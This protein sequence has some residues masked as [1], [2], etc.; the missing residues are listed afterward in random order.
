MG[1]PNQRPRPGLPARPDLGRTSMILAPEQENAGTRITCTHAREA[2]I[3]S[4]FVR[5]GPPSGPQI[6]SGFGPPHVHF[7]GEMSFLEMF[8][9]LRFRAF[10]QFSHFSPISRILA[11]SCSSAISLIKWKCTNTHAAQEYFLWLG[12]RFSHFLILG[13]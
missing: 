5:F 11:Q 4:A 10:S 2:L 6:S 1:A 7:Q 3:T 12:L 8:V 13:P 9:I